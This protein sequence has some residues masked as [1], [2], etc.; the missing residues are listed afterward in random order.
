MKKI[1]IE[2]TVSVDDS[3]SLCP[4]SDINLS[5]TT[6]DRSHQ[7]PALSL[8]DNHSGRCPALNLTEVPRKDSTQMR[9]SPDLKIKGGEVG[10]CDKEMI[11]SGADSRSTPFKDENYDGLSG[12]YLGPSRTL[13]DYDI[14]Y[15]NGDIVEAEKEVQDSYR[16]PSP[17]S[18]DSFSGIYIGPEEKRNKEAAMRRMS[19]DLID[20]NYSPQTPDPVS[21]F[22]GEADSA[23]VGSLEAVTDDC[24]RQ[25]PSVC[26]LTV[27]KTVKKKKRSRFFFTTTSQ[28]N[29]SSE[30][31]NDRRGIERSKTLCLRMFKKS[32]NITD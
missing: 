6:S 18:L 19:L 11:N 8:S 24:R 28:Q 4:D 13:E 15:L 26:A 20:S 10:G 2:S 9:L 23:C 30:E 22:E 3:S 14:E 16:P 25:C 31:K 1:E 27:E 5:T 17:L 7:C 29:S 21:G 12:V 32:F